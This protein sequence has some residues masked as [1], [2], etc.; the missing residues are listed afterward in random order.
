LEFPSLPAHIKMGRSPFQKGDCVFDWPLSHA[1]KAPSCPKLQP[2]Y[3][4]L[5]QENGAFLRP[6]IQRIYLILCTSTSSS[7]EPPPLT[8]NSCTQWWRRLPRPFPLLL[9]CRR[10][11]RHRCRHCCCCRRHH[12]AAAIAFVDFVIVVAVIVAVSAAVAAA[13]FS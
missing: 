3:Q 1:P 7:F 13:A 8:K 2:H 5:R 12:R 11:A 10:D 9:R 4:K 6:P